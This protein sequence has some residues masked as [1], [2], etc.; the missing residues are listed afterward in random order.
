MK[1]G[2]SKLGG[3]LGIVYCIAGFFF[4]FLG[5]NGAASNDREAAQL[6]YVISGGLAGLGLI[7]VGAALIVANSLRTDR[8][9]L[10]AAIDDLRTT[11]AAPASPVGATA[12]SSAPNA[13]GSGD[14][15]VAGSHSYHR[16][17]CSL[18]EG[19]ADQA[20]MTL[21]EARQAGRSACRLCHPDD[22]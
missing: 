10:R 5:W 3:V 16:P 14:L 4:I 22:R 15:V 17:E 21:A 6:P 9:E 1:N 2:W 13:G 18:V 19:Q 20:T 7:V 11:S 8:V 12:V